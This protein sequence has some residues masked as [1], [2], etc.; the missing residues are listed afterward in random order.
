ML[1]PCVRHQSLLARASLTVAFPPEDPGSTLSW[2][3]S[4]A[5]VAAL[6][7]VKTG[8][9]NVRSPIWQFGDGRVCRV[10]AM[11]PPWACLLGPFC[12]PELFKGATASSSSTG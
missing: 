9:A 1:H 7:H 12:R 4:H 2:C 10:S 3:R 5:C 6:G 8:A 11:T